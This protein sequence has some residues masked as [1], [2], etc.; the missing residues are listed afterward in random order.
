MFRDEDLLCQGL[1]LNDDL[2][3]VLTKHDSIASGTA[4]SLEKVKTLQARDVN[5]ATLSTQDK[6]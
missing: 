6:G 5:N 4:M 1:A 3:R 2:Q